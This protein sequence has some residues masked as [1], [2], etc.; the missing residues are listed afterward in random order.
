MNSED[1]IYNRITESAK[2]RFDYKNFESDFE[3]LPK[4]IPENLIFGV[5]AGY[6][7]GDTKETI[8]AKLLNEILMMG[9]II[10][11]EEFIDFVDNKK[12]LFGLEIYVLQLS[13]S[14][15]DNGDHPSD[16][17]KSVNQFLN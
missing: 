10:N 2:K 6:A 9:F 3:G 14:M 7:N 4:N 16:V 15:L 12:K 17:L 5:I 13:T 1:L 11:R 8:A